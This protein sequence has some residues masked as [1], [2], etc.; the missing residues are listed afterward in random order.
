MSISPIFKD[1]DLQKEFNK[2]GFVKVT[3]F[4]EDEV[5]A[6]KQFYQDNCIPDKQH[7]G[8]SVSI[9]E[10]DDALRQ[11]YNNFY[12]NEVFPSFEKIF[13]EPKFF[14]GS[15]MI[16]EPIPTGTVAAHQDWT[17]VD[18]KKFYSIMCWI[19]LD[20]VNIENGA[21]AFL[22]GSHTI[23]SQLRGFPCPLVPEPVEQYRYKLMPYLEVVETKKGEVLIF[24][25]KTIHGSYPNMTATT[26]HGI[27]IT[28]TQK[29]A[30][31]Y[32]Y[33]LKPKS[34]NVLIKYKV[35]NDFFDRYNNPKFH[36]HYKKKKLLDNLEFVEEVRLTPQS[37]SWDELRIK[38]LELGNVYHE[39]NDKR[40]GK[41]MEE[42]EQHHLKS[43]N[44]F[45]KQTVFQKLMK[46]VAGGKKYFFIL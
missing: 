29:D 2:N 45:R 38:V 40:F 39:D 42:Q 26:R 34:G 11:K 37:L 19:S 44:S 24:D 3:L 18:E 21:M 17:F 22:K 30:E 10:E 41:L 46:L 4:T 32:A 5:T 28:L 1:K 20:N 25:N 14:T 16:K 13:I 12:L 7:Y 6:F 36:E 8:F 35:D 9:D 33:Y 23:F 27:S 31:F 15:F 43:L